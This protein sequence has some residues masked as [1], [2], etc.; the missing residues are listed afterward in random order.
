MHGNYIL[1]NLTAFIC[2]VQ[3]VIQA[4]KH[5]RIDIQE[6]KV[7]Q[8]CNGPEGASSSEEGYYVGGEMPSTRLCSAMF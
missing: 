5:Q 3:K 6:G 1:E 8:G 7:E 4:G 2:R